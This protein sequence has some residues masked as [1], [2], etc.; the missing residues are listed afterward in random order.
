M[1]RKNL[2]QR[3]A[4]AGGSAAVGLLCGGML[5]AFAASVSEAAAGVIVTPLLASLLGAWAA[6]LPG[7]FVGAICGG[8]LVGLASVVAATGWTLALTVVGGGV[9]AGWLRWRHVREADKVVYLKSGAPRPFGANVAL[10][11]SN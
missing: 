8:M 7:A 6:R 9:L 10:T 5:A 4:A 3:I 11:P 1:T 2:M